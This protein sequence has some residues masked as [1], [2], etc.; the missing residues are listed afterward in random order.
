M[1][2]TDMFQ[3]ISKIKIKQRSKNGPLF[4]LGHEVC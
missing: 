1:E 2:L 4:F 3:A